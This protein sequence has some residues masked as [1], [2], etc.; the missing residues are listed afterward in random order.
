L[1]TMTRHEM[2]F[3]SISSCP[4]KMISDSVLTHNE[5]CTG[6]GSLTALTDCHEF[7]SYLILII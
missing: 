3:G 2:S 4:S 7:S 5:S 1:S 6:P